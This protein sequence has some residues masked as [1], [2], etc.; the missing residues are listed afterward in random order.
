[1]TNTH[2]QARENAD[3]ARQAESRRILSAVDAQTDGMGLTA[4]L[5]RHFSGGDADPNDQV[6]ILGRRIGRGLSLVLCIA[7]ILWLAHRLS[8]F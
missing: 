4:R 3:A 5:G 1:M 2:H 7:L 8:A 6:E